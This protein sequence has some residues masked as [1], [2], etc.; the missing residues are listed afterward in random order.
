MQL[1][2]SK[3]QHCQLAASTWMQRLAVTKVSSFRFLFRTAGIAAHIH[4][5]L[6]VFH[7]PRVQCRKSN[8]AGNGTTRT[9]EWNVLGLNNTRPEFKNKM[10]EIYYFLFSQIIT[11]QN[12]SG[13]RRGPMTKHHRSHH[14][15]YRFL[16]C[17]LTAWLMLS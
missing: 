14:I 9:T 17:S 11:A 13:G 1:A 15:L 7:A 10:K 12:Y 8:Y 4:T 2:I 16:V 5:T 3:S 6:F